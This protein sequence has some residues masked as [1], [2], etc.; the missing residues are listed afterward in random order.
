MVR[1]TCRDAMARHPDFGLNPSA[2]HTFRNELDTAMVKEF[3]SSLANNVNFT[4]TTC[5]YPRG[6]LQEASVILLLHA[7]DFGSGW[8]T[9]LHKHHGKGAFVTM[10]AGVEALFRSCPGGVLTSKWLETGVSND[11]VGA[12]FQIAGNLELESLVDLIHQVIVELGV[13]CRP[14]GSLETFVEQTLAKYASSTTPA[15]DFV[16]AL[17]QS[18]PST[19]NDVYD[20]A[21]FYKKA[22]LVVGELFH[23]FR[24]E[25]ERFAFVDG[26][27]LTA[28]ID[29]V[30]CATLR[31]K[32]ILIL[33]ESLTAMIVA[34]QELPKA[35]TFEV[36]LRATAMCAVEAIVTDM[37]LTSTELGNYLW[38]GLGKDPVVRVYTRHASKT[39]FY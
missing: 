5:S 17:V 21:C 11:H 9:E 32:G 8:R 34:G 26:D 39:V 23:R 6:V 7:L 29:N 27:H 14:Y 20:E 2:I 13:G 4:G 22:Q 19:F 10:K 18:F 12:C 3:G 15:G 1:E 33:P 24:K 30:I 36:M 31:Y 25:D 28:F 38:G 37:D 16:W 35:S